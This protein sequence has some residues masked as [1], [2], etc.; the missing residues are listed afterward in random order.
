MD[1]TVSKVWQPGDELNVL[2]FRAFIAD[3]ETVFNGG[4]EATAFQRDPNGDIVLSSNLDLGGKEILGASNVPTGIANVKA[5]GAGSS[6]NDVTIQRALESIADDGYK[7]AFFPS[8]NYVFDGTV[9]VPTEMTLFGA[10]ASTRFEQTSRDAEGGTPCFTVTNSGTTVHDMTFDTDWD[11]HNI[12]VQVT[13]ADRFRGYN[14]YGRNLGN[15]VRASDAKHIRLDV[16]RA[17]GVKT[18]LSM[19]GCIGGKVSNVFHDTI[20]AFIGSVISL[21]GCS[22][23]TL[24][25]LNLRHGSVGVEMQG[26]TACSLQGYVNGMEGAGISLNGC[27]MCKITNSWSLHN[28]QDRKAPGIELVGCNGVSVL[29]TFSFCFGAPSQQTYGVVI[30]GGTANMIGGDGLAPNMGPNGDDVSDRWKID[31]RG[32]DTVIFAIDVPAIG[33]PTEPA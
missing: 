24:E 20:S 10:G 21:K 9:N 15:I 18:P 31:N 26:C 6:P 8:D 12:G 27:S 5:H 19:S 14:L 17:V 29:G 22:G 1:F 4:I 7:S 11:G 28:A 23:V 2:D 33:A 32:E 16:L 3:L 13:G 30:D 25:A